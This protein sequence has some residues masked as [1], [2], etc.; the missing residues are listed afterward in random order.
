MPSTVTY[1]VLPV[2]SRE[3][4]TMLEMSIPKAFIGKLSP[5]IGFRVRSVHTG[6]VLLEESMVADRTWPGSVAPPSSEP[7]MPT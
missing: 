1:T 3:S 5:E 7:Y 6:T 2:A 4:M